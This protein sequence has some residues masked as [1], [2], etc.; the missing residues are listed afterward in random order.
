MRLRIIAFAT[1]LVGVLLVRG[2]R[3]VEIFAHRGASADAPENTLAAFKLGYAHGADGVELDI[4]LTRDNQLAVIHDADTRRTGGVDKRVVDQSLEDLR[5]LNVGAFGD[6]KGKGFVEKIP[7]LDEVLALV[8]KG[9]KLV[10]EIKCGVEA[11]DP[12]EQSLRRSE[13]KPDQAVIITFH[14]DVAAAAKKRFASHEVYWLYDYKK[15]PKSGQFPVID[16]LIQKAQAAGVDGLN[17]N[18]RFPLDRATVGRIKAARLQCYA[19]TVDDP[20]RARELTAAG[21]DGLT[22]N[23]PA[24]LRRELSAAP[25]KDAARPPAPGAK[26]AEA[27][28]RGN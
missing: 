28:A 14:Y 16:D 17:L 23:R 26:P 1:L 19:W 18:H 13:V 2:A 20:I 12:L 11:L 25:A 24:W 6:W 3:G 9:R 15:D 10:I 27:P 4:H 21:V 5:A 22:T 8:P 7:T